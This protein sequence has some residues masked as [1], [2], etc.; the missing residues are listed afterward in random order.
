MSEPEIFSSIATAGLPALLMA[1]AIRYLMKANEKQAESN[2]RL[3]ARLDQERSERLDAMEAHIQ[4][5]DKDRNELRQQLMRVLGMG[6]GE[7]RAKS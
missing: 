4:A 3:I 5:C 1:I 7:L 6:S 2:E